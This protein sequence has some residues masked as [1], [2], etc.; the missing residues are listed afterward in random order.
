MAAWAVEIDQHSALVAAVIRDIELRRAELDT[1]GSHASEISLA[2]IPF[3]PLPASTYGPSTN[4]GRQYP[5]RSP[6]S[7]WI[8]RGV[9]S[10]TGTYISCSGA[11][12]SPW[13]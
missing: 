1:F 6:E 7:G 5:P 12:Y 2:P 4:L 10:G 8:S 3:S 13:K 9:P 11:G